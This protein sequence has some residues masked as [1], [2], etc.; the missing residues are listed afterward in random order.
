LT[1]AFEQ[2]RTSVSDRL[3]RQAAVIWVAEKPVRFSKRDT[4]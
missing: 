2:R 4:E 1:S 3:G